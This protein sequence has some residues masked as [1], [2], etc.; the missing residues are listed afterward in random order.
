MRGAMKRVLVNGYCHGAIPASAVT[1]MF[2]LFRLKG[3]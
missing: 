2:R 1:V 3:V